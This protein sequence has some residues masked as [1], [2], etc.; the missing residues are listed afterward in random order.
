MKT[1]WK[2]SH[3]IFLSFLLFGLLIAK[4]DQPKT[5]DVLINL[6]NIVEKSNWNEISKFIDLNKDI[7]LDDLTAISQQQK[8]KALSRAINAVIAIKNSLQ[9]TSISTYQLLKTALYMET[10][11]SKHTQLNQYYIPLE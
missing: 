5:T 4:T 10:Q 7:S 2:N 9:E 6:H 3:Y 1:L 11:L 8:P